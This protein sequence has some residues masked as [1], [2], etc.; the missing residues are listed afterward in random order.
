MR[1]V[2]ES[3]QDRAN[4][5]QVIS[6]LSQKWHVQANKNPKFYPVDWSLSKDGEV[7]AM[8]EI[9]VRNR[10]Y[11]T[12]IISSRKWADAVQA[13][14]ALGIPYLLAVCWPE[15]GKQVVRY[16]KVAKGIHDRI[17]HGG[18]SDRGDS[19]DMEPMTEISM[20]K[21]TLAGEL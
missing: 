16:I 3:P 21:F 9:K 5:E 13:S 8:V 19:Q 4:E 2:Y 14:E 15:M 20:T 6:F 7:K 1:P 17:V 12:Y 18:R 10:S 11:P